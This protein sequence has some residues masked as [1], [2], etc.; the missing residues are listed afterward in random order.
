[1]TVIEL[2]NAIA[3]GLIAV[4]LL[5][6]SRDGAAHRP[7]ASAL[8]YLVIVAAGAVAVFSVAGWLHYVGAAQLVLNVVL[9]L[10]VQA[11]RG[12]IVELCSLSD[13]SDSLITRLL[14]KETWTL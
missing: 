2:L 8:A 1:M 11:T 4:R 10:A 6:Y 5:L 7:V 13:G 14:R 12:N 9:C 3:C